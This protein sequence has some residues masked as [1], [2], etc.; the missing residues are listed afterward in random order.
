MT[1]RNATSSK[2]IDVFALIMG[3]S[4]LLLVLAQLSWAGNIVSGK[5]AVGEID[6]F[7]LSAVRWCLALAILVPFALP[8]VRRD[9]EEIKKGWYWLFIYGGLGFATFNILIYGAA[10]FTSAVN[11]SMEQAAVP[12]LVMVGNFV[13]FR[14]R[15][16]LLHIIGVVLTIYGVVHVATH[17]E[18]G[19]ILGLDVNI[20][21]GMVLL[22]CAC[23]AAYSLMLRFRPAIHWISFLFCTT[24]A[25]AFMALFYQFVF[26]G[27]P[28]AFV[29]ELIQ[30][31]LNGWAIV[32]YV[33]IFPSIVAQ[34]CYARGVELIG[35]NRASLFINLLPVLGAA[36]SVMLVGESLELFH[37][38][39]AIFI[40][41]G[42]VLAEY[43]ARRRLNRSL[44]PPV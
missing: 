40:I 20:G 30:T 34:L 35:P 13:V 5:M 19:R 28:V 44:K 33:A 41:G 24:A 12:V 3:Q 9:W 7:A 11:V 43:A 32:L 18:P 2:R 38:V 39:A 8:Y 4:Y 27:G 29:E 17:G 26:G 1:K 36:L 14:V 37:Y 16:T 15:A 23:Y 25:A 42:I 22:A 6:A 21:D 10:N 31:S